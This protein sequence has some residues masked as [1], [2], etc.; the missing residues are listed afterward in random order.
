MI[1]AQYCAGPPLARG[2]DGEGCSVVWNRL[3]RR[4][5]FSAMP[6]S[7]SSRRE[8]GC[9]RAGGIVRRTREPAQIVVSATTDLLGASWSGSSLHSVDPIQ[10]SRLIVGTT[11]PE[12]WKKVAKPD[13]IGQT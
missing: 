7:P 10:R 11:K 2:G 9:W 8:R 4:S 5:F 3:L 12:R 13:W 1:P 6:S